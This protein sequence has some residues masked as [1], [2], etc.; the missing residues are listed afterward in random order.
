L[1]SEDGAPAYEPGQ[2]ELRL[3]TFDAAWFAA[4]PLALAHDPSAFAPSATAPWLNQGSLLPEVPTDRDG[5]ARHA[6][7]DLGPYER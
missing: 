6:P 2:S 3:T 4:F 5:T 7:V 1:G